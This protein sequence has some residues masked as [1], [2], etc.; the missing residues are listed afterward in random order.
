MVT[1]HPARVQEAIES[2][3]PTSVC[4]A[5]GAFARSVVAQAAPPSLARAK[6]FLF[7]AAQLGEFAVSIGVE[8]STAVLFD[9]ALVERFILCG[10]EGHAA[11]TRRTLRTSLRGLARS[12]APRIGPGATPLP[13]ERAKAPYSQ[14]EIDT[15]L[16]LAAAQP[17]RA[18]RLRA[19]G[20][21]ALG[22]G[23]GCSGADLRGVRGTD[24]MA[25][26]GGL[27]VIVGGKK[28]RV[29]PVLARYHELLGESAAFAGERYVVGGHDPR[30]NNVTT[31]LI[32]SLAGGVDLA[33]LDAGRLRATWLMCCAEAIGLSAF[34][35]A[36]GLTCSQRLGDLVASAP[37]PSEAQTVALLGGCAE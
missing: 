12:V 37:R 5:A 11:G 20:L 32:S 2:F 25:R 29:V 28:A 35:A 1:D 19:S 23:A 27:V 16:A 30:R 34:M 22:A 18:R 36:A 6:A 4:P 26:S 3:S 10:T 9:E 13:R 7:A 8:P 33:R 14:G 21:I 24:V 15:Y 17:T 31:P